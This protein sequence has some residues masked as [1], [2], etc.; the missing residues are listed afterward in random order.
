[1]HMDGIS[2]AFRRRFSSCTYLAW[3]LEEFGIYDLLV[4][5]EYPVPQTLVRSLLLFL[6]A[7]ILY[8]HR[9]VMGN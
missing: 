7:V 8:G 4:A 9:G 2:G 5:D 6:P 3:S 1:M